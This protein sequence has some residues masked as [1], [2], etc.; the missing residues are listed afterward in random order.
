[1]EFRMW[2]NFAFFGFFGLHSLC[3]GIRRSV[4]FCFSQVVALRDFSHSMMSCGHALFRFLRYGVPNEFIQSEI[5]Q[6]PSELSLR[7]FRRPLP[8]DGPEL[9]ALTSQCTLAYFSPGT[10]E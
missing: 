4:D 1:M 9:T 8:P 3:G 6:E 2:Q 5:S 7:S 10:L